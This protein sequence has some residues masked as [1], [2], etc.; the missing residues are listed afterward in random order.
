VCLP[1][2]G[3]VI[4]CVNRSWFDSS[5]PSLILWSANTYFETLQSHRWERKLHSKGQMW[6]SLV[7]HS[8]TMQ[9]NVADAVI[10]TFPCFNM[11]LKYLNI[12]F[13][14]GSSLWC[15]GRRDPK[16]WMKPLELNKRY[17]E[18]GPLLSS[19]WKW[20]LYSKLF[21]LGVVSVPGQT[22]SAACLCP[23]SGTE[24]PYRL[25]RTLNPTGFFYYLRA[26][27]QSLSVDHRI[28]I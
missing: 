12:A 24:R 4:L 6:T 20:H 16:A 22:R 10:E 1:P 11:D 18:A 25:A 23:F 8:S 7:K 5:L 26:S 9:L 13:S 15:L 2:P 19:L 17:W 28:N 27:I 21:P 3:S 14:F